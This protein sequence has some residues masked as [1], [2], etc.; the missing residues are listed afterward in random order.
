MI[1]GKRGIAVT[2]KINYQVNIYIEPEY[3]AVAAY[4][5]HVTKEKIYGDEYLQVRIADK[6]YLQTR[7]G[8]YHPDRVHKIGSV[9]ISLNNLISNI[10]IIQYSIVRPI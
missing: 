1:V 3:L 8:S 9:F 5:I 2:E 6:V 10:I 7:L 4:P